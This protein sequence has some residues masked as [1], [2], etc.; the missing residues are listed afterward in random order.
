M[1]RALLVLLAG[2]AACAGGP[3]AARNTSPAFVGSPPTPGDIRNREAYVVAQDALPPPRPRNGEGVVV[4]EPSAGRVPDVL[5][6]GQI[7]A[8]TRAAV[9]TDEAQARLAGEHAKDPRVRAL[10]N[11]IAQDSG[12]TQEKEAIVEREGKVAVVASAEAERI[13]SA[14]QRTY[15]RL[16]ESTGAGF[17]SAYVESQ[18]AASRE[19]LDLIDRRLLPSASDATVRAMLRSMRPDLERRYDRM[20]ALQQKID[21]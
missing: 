3:T 16:V 10:A 13:H 19:L 15:D 18:V 2:G 14:G 1:R 6:D 7:L 12:R 5:E 20:R 21:K 17:D 11:T 8:I 4:P 9:Q